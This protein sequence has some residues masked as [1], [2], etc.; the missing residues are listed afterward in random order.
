MRGF[1]KN[2]TI[3]ALLGSGV[4]PLIDTNHNDVGG[5]G[6]FIQWPMPTAILY[7]ECFKL[8]FVSVTEKTFY[9]PDAITVGLGRGSLLHLIV[10]LTSSRQV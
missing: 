1:P 10:A 4:P 9:S 8:T 5:D 7:L 6:H 2:P 3:P